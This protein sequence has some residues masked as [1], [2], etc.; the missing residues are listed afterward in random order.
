MAVQFTAYSCGEQNEFKVW[1]YAGTS[2][3][4]HGEKNPVHHSM[5]IPVIKLIIIAVG[6]R[7]SVAIQVVSNSREEYRRGWK[8]FVEVEK[9]PENSKKILENSKSLD[10]SRK[11][12]R[13]RK[14]NP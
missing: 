12:S 8:K 2:A 6:E 13:T 7:V 4:L 1:L 14:K 10:N 5:P 9:N 11:I 3:E